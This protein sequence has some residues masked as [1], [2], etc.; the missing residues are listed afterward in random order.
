M[1]NTDLNVLCN[2]I[3][4]LASC[5]LIFKCSRRYSLILF[6]ISTGI[7]MGLET[8]KLKIDWIQIGLSIIIFI[9][10]ATYILNSFDKDYNLKPKKNK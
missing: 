8:I 6:A 10:I 2:S 7:S 3:T 5:C 9:V 1:S 4:L